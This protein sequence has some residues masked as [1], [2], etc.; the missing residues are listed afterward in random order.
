[1]GTG[2][3]N[4]I[5][6]I[7]CFIAGILLHRYKRMPVNAPAVLNRFII[8]VSLPSLTLPYV[9]DLKFSSHVILMAA[10]VWIC[11][12]LAAGFFLFLGRRLALP[13]RTVGA[14]ILTGGLGGERLLEELQDDPLPRIC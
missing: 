7:L 14:L 1:M 9:H 2:M 10:M 3:N 11:F 13:Q 12:A 6:L 8:H 5:L 4:I